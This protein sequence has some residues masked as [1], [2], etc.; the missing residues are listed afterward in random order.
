ML[1]IH[2]DH[3]LPVTHYVGVEMVRIP[4][5]QVRVSSYH[6]SLGHTLKGNRPSE[7]GNSHRLL[8]SPGNRPRFPRTST[9]YTDSDYDASGP[10]LVSEAS[11]R[12]ELSWPRKSLHNR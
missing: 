8:P 4:Y 3:F 5:S 6:P 9:S 2:K 12:H 7:F 10:C 11:G 1:V